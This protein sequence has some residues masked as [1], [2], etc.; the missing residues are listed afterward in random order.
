MVLKTKTKFNGYPLILGSP[1]LET[2]DAYSDY[3]SG[4]VTITHGQSLKKIT[5]CPPSGTF[6]ED[7]DA[8]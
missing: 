2:I 6:L 1:C 4:G 5:L 7:D 8:L 3:R